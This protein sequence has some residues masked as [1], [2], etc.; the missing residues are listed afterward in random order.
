Q[1]APG[2]AEGAPARKMP[3]SRGRA[4][5]SVQPIVTQ[6]SLVER[7]SVARGAWGVD[8]A[9]DGG[10]VV[11]LRPMSC[12]AQRS[13]STSY[14]SRRSIRR[15]TA[16]GRTLHAPLLRRVVEDGVVGFVRLQHPVRA[17]QVDVRER[18]R[19][20]GSRRRGNVDL[21]APADVE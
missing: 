4:A 18:G 1:V 7:A 16:H 20:E 2:V 3:K 12:R 21:L 14:A 10:I 8:R 15:S 5:G 17:V 19:L 9:I 13:I 6:K 11:S